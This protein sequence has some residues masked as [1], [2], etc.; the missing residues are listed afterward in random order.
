MVMLVFNVCLYNYVFSKSVSAVVNVTKL[1]K[2]CHNNI[3]I[4]AF[5]INFQV[6]LTEVGRLLSEYV[7]AQKSRNSKVLISCVNAIEHLCNNLP[8]KDKLRKTN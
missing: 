7:A 3:V 1:N 6:F 8:F 4:D 2:A 5:P